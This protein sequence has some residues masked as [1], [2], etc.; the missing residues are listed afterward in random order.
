M[1]FSDIFNAVKGPLAS[2][3]ASLIPG[4]PLILGAV[5]A[6]LPDDK[7]LP[8]TATGQQIANAV[9]S[10]TPEQRASLMEKRIDLQIAREEGATERYKAMAASDGQETRARIVNR[11]M[12]TLMAISAVF[13]AAT[14][15]VYVEQGAEAAFSV[16]MAGVFITVSGTFAYV[17][18]AYFGD[19]R[20]E[21]KSRHQVVDAKPQPLGVLASLISS[22][23]K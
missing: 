10:L 14:A 21:A 20:S 7:K 16:E 23:L 4:G 3:A 22:R 18:R 5:N 15:W 11:A 2:V 17:I 9:E 1:N 19:L 8:E 13:V 6:L 12:T